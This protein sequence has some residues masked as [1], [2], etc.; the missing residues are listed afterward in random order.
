MHIC[1]WVTRTTL[2]AA[3]AV[4]GLHVMTQ[5][6]AAAQV[7]KAPGAHSACTDVN[8]TKR[9]RKYTQ[10]SAQEKPG[11]ARVRAARK[12]RLDEV[13]KI[14]QTAGVRF[15][16]RQLFLRVFKKEM[17]LE[18]WASGQR[19]GPLTHVTSYR[20][21]QSSGDPGPKKEEGDGQVPEGFYSI[22]HLNNRSSFHLSMLISYPN[23][24]DRRLRR[25]GSAIMIHGSCVSVGCLAMSDER[26]EELWLMA[27]AVYGRRRI[28]VHIF[29]SCDMTKMIT[30]SRD[31][32]LKSFWENI[33]EGLNAFE[34]RKVVPL[35]SSDRR[36]RYRFR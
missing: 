4:A 19:K 10:W 14:F 24:R 18:V 1:T 20:I 25:T 30:T 3:V 22:R 21:C 34:R 5:G 28:P 2:A 16:P 9:L 15:P 17:V 27:S 36:G 32:K 31:K 35:V 26:I 12:R 7:V 6:S 8:D 23:R 33:R 29:P 11:V 13:R